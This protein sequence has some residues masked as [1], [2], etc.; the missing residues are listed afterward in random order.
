MKPTLKSQAARIA[1]LE[2]LLAA[3]TEPAPAPEAQF[4][5]YPGLGHARRVSGP[6]TNPV[7]KGALCTRNGQELFVQGYFNDNTWNFTLKEF[8]TWKRVTE[9]AAAPVGEDEFLGRIELD[10]HTYTLRCRYGV[11]AT[12]GANILK[13]KL[14]DANFNVKLKNGFPVGKVA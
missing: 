6:T 1:E 4:K 8:G 3:K 13:L 5:H 11:T 12:K 9:V 2:A 7:V 14:E 10:G